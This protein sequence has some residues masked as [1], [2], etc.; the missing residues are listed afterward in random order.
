MSAFSFKLPNGESFEIKMPSG[1]TFEQAQ[2][3]FKQQ[4]DSGGLT[5]FKVGDALRAAT[6]A[7]DGLAGAAGVA[8]GNGT[9]GHNSGTDDLGGN[10]T[11]SKT[12]LL[13]KA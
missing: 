10:G 11:V 5:G 3:V 8:G 4:V 9:V 13:K 12:F 1:A 6:Q 7:A 2:A